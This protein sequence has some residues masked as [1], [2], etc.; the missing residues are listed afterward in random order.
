M[1]GSFLERIKSCNGLRYKEHRDL[2]WLI[3]SKSLSESLLPQKHFS[4]FENINLDDLYNQLLEASSPQIYKPNSRLG[5][6]AEGLLYYF[7]ENFTSWEILDSNI[8]LI[9]NKITV[10]EIDFLLSNKESFIHLEFAI[11]YYLICQIENNIEY[12][13]PNFRDNWAQKKERLLN[14]QIQLTE[15]H[16]HLL[17]PSYQ[18]IDFEKNALILGQLFETDDSKLAKGPISYRNIDDFQG[19]YFCILSRKLDWI[20]PFCDTFKLIDRKQL[21]DDILD[22]CDQAV[23][24]VCY[25]EKKRPLNWGF[26]Y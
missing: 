4:L 15:S 16:K 7:I 18:S 11:K 10:G 9:E 25:D 12:W 19:D 14:K 24:L 26:L 13:G 2:F 20:F 21:K 8:Q 3:N 22:Y 5:K 6:Y 1:D 17:K 23:M